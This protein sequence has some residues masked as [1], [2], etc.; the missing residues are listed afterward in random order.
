MRTR[1]LTDIKIRTFTESQRNNRGRSVRQ[2]HDAGR[3][4]FHANY[5]LGSRTS[6]G[7]RLLHHGANGG[8]RVL[9]GIVTAPW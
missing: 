7:K 4:T 3:S 8:H 5:A 9:S 1:E 2:L 6:A